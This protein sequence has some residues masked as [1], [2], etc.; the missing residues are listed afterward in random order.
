MY[1][2]NALRT[3]GLSL[4]GQEVEWVGYGIGAKE[5]VYNYVDSSYLRIAIQNGIIPLLVVLSIY[6]KMLKE[7]SDQNNIIVIITILFVLL[8]CFTEPRLFDF[9]FNPFPLLSLSSSQSQLRQFD[10]H[11]KVSTFSVFQIIKKL[12]I[13]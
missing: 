11:S 3:Y 6:C 4:F 7:A 10:E 2:Q 8:L 1:G 9:A 5:G 13:R 12:F